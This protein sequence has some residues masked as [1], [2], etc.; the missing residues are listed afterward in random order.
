[1]TY[2]FDFS[3]INAWR[4][5]R[6]LISGPRTT[7]LADFKVTEGGRD[8]WGTVYRL[9]DRGSQACNRVSFE[10]RLCTRNSRTGC[11]VS[12]AEGAKAALRAAAE[13]EFRALLS[14]WIDAGEPS[15]Y[16]QRKARL[17]AEQAQAL[18]ASEALE[19]VATYEGLAEQLGDSHH[20]NNARDHREV[21]ED[22]PKAFDLMATYEA[23]AQV[24]ERLDANDRSNRRAL[25]NS[26]EGRAAQLLAMKRKVYGDRFATEAEAEAQQGDPL[27]WLEL[28]AEFAAVELGLD[29]RGFWAGDLEIERARAEIE[30]EGL[31]A[32]AKALEVEALASDLAEAQRSDHLEQLLQASRAALFALEGVALL[33]GNREI[34][35]YAEQLGQAL[36]PFAEGA[37]L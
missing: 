29:R 3:P 11:G 26:W 30:A 1:M 8:Y 17:E 13:Q 12:V 7:H 15:T 37:A 6:E 2:K 18:A 20:L 31:E 9:F 32:K 19:A 21:L 10:V 35:A 34:A 33:Q 36:A 22:N 27:A 25:L 16:E 5:S 28:I 24:R 4:N 23:I 14:A